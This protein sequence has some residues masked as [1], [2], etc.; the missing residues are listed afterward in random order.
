M[1]NVMIKNIA[2]AF[3]P[4]LYRARS[5]EVKADK[6]KWSLVH[7]VFFYGS[8]MFPGQILSLH[9]FEPRYKVRML[10]DIFLCLKYPLS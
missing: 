10:L 8:C 7:P 3:N 5:E 9:L 4:Q 1:Q 2:Y 6:L